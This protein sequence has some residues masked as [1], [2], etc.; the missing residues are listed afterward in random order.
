[1]SA[2]PSTLTLWVPPSS[3]AGSGETSDTEWASLSVQRLRDSEMPAITFSNQDT[4]QP[5]LA[6]YS[7]VMVGSASSHVQLAVETDH[8]APALTGLAW[9]WD[10]DYWVWGEGTS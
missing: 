10:P 3:M 2:D 8:K 7:S 4:G 5:K 1:M 6:R 9:D